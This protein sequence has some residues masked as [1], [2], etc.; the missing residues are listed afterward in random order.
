MAHRSSLRRG[1]AGPG[2]E[3]LRLAVCFT[4]FALPICVGLLIPAAAPAGNWTNINPGGGG[5]FTP[6]GAGPTGTII[7]GSDLSGAYRSRDR[8]LTWDAIGFNRGLKRTHVSTVGFDSVDPRVVHLGAGIGIYR[9]GNGG[10]SFQQ[11]L[12]TG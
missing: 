3:N 10:D 11:V 2:F 8:G 1:V 12:T 6:I 9:S 4:A 5:A 7:C